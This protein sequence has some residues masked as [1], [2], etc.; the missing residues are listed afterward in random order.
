MLKAAASLRATAM[1]LATR[2]ALA[3]LTMLV[4]LPHPTTL[5]RL[6]VRLTPTPLEPPPPVT[7]SVP[8][9]KSTVVKLDKMLVMAQ[10]RSPATVLETAPTLPS[11]TTSVAAKLQ[12]PSRCVVSLLVIT[13][14]P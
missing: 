9:T 13:R 1:R 8:V 3:Q 12:V 6:L 2:S 7:W 11:A 5:I 14:H 10:P 4:T